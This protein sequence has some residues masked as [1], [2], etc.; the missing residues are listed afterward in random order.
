MP[1]PD[2]APVTR[3]CL[4]VMSNIGEDMVEVMRWKRDF[5]ERLM[6]NL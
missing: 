2:P 6:M 4:P 1:I 3:A 5:E